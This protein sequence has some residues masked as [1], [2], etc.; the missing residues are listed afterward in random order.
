MEKKKF[1]L[2]IVTLGGTDGDSSLFFQRVESS[3]T[4]MSVK[5]NQRV[6]MVK[7]NS[8][9]SL[10]RVLVRCSSVAVGVK[11]KRYLTQIATS[12]LDK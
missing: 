2:H 4:P 12:F 3:G 5:T 8:F 10:K 11:R 1:F 9:T 6:I 7:V